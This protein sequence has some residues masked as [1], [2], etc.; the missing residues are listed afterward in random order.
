MAAARTG[1]PSQVTASAA[2]GSTSVTVPADC[3]CVVAF[4]CHFNVLG[5]ST[6]STL[7]LGGNSFTTRSEIATKSPTANSTG[8]GV[9]TLTNLPGTGT[10]TVAWAWSD[11]DAR[12][13]GGGLFLVYVKGVDTASLVHDSDTTNAT[14]SNAVALTLDTGLTDLLLAACESF[15][16]TNPGLDATVFINDVTINSEV[17]D[18][19]DI[20]PGATTTTINMSGESDSAMAAISLR[21]LAL[22]DTGLAWVRA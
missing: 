11:A 13:E 19:S 8:V 22:T 12:D 21:A 17:Y 14:G 7:T 15:T 1:T 16:G 2:S 4:W 5:S 18:L 20:T 3:T 10:Q 9:A 6:L